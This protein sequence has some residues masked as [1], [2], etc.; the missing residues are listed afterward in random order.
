M[1]SVFFVCT[2]NAISCALTRDNINIAKTNFIEKL[3][4]FAVFQVIVLTCPRFSD[5]I[6]KIS[7]LYRIQ[8]RLAY[9]FYFQ[10]PV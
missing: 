6:G 10:F 3:A 7:A 9:G 1:S 5:K 2:A 4:L 8:A